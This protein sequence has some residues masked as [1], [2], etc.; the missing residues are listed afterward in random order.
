MTQFQSTGTPNRAVER[1]ASSVHAGCF[2]DPQSL[3]GSRRAPRKPSLTLFSLG[4]ARA[5]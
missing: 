5:L 4:V 3:T 2:A 1:T